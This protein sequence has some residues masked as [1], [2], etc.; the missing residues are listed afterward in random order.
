MP[1]PGA[2]LPT[3]HYATSRLSGGEFVF[4]PGDQGLNPEHAHWPL[5]TM[6]VLMQLS[7]GGFTL[8]M[9]RAAWS[10]AAENDARHLFFLCL[11]MCW[12]GLAASL[13]HLGRPI[14]AYRALVGLRH[15]WLSREVLAFG[16]FAALATLY[17]GPAALGLSKAAMSLLPVVGAGV[18]G[19]I[20][21]VMVYHAVRR[22]FWSARYTAVKFV[23]SAL[24]LGLAASLAACGVSRVMNQPGLASGTSFSTAFGVMALSL[25]GATTAKLCYEAWLARRLARSEQAVLRLS[26]RLLAGPLAGPVRLRCALGVVGGVVLPSLALATSVAGQHSVAATGAAVLAL[27]VSIGGEFAER[28]L[29]FT[30]VVA[31]KAPGGTLS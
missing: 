5:V 1:V 4:A 20:C 9:V 16:L 23:G 27:A 18:T 6:L 29:F 17:A 31:P 13:F 30:A 7:A 19:I 22:P 21:S 11:A 24:L 15:S 2:A 25:I 14:Y 12:T 10:P 28:Y 26:V 8:Q 3:T